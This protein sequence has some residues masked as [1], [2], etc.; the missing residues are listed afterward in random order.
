MTLLINS[1]F[2]DIVSGQRTL[3]QVIWKEGSNAHDKCHTFK[4]SDC[5]TLI[6]GL[7][8]SR[9]GQREEGMCVHE[10]L[11]LDSF[12]KL[13]QEPLALYCS[14]PDGSRVPGQTR[15]ST[16]FPLSVVPSGCN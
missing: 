11:C 4:W 8:F 6:Q 13:W 9:S 1:S 2:K 12:G 15:T 14:Y 3:L 7:P 5:H 10:C 16:D